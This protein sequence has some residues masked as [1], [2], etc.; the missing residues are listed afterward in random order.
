MC[1]RRNVARQVKAIT[2]STSSIKARDGGLAVARST[3]CRASGKLSAGELKSS[4][5][6]FAGAVVPELSGV[7]DKRGLP[8]SPPQPTVTD[9]VAPALRTGVDSGLRTA[10]LGFR[11]MLRL[12]ALLALTSLLLSGAGEV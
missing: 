10:M 6:G 12:Q 8:G 1:S 5:S 4:L 2:P 9:L 7:L 11:S 3:A